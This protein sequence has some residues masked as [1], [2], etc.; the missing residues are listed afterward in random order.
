MFSI[1]YSGWKTEYKTS[2]KFEKKLFDKGTL[3]CSMSH[4]F[5]RSTAGIL[6]WQTVN[7]QHIILESAAN[8]GFRRLYQL[9]HHGKPRLFESL[10][11]PKKDGFR[12]PSHWLGPNR[13][14]WLH[15]DTSFYTNSWQ[16]R[17]SSAALLGFM[18]CQRRVVQLVECRELGQFHLTF[19]RRDTRD[20]TPM[21]PNRWVVFS[22]GHDY[23]CNSKL[24]EKGW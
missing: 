2:L 22:W 10:N 9:Y 1:V 20:C 13:Y 12:W 8:L 19:L 15:I 21:G 11:P 7:I 16:L 5:L 24:F 14:P 23:N 4:P 6:W 3:L 18:A 17:K